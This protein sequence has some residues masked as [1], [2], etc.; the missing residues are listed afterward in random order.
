[1]TASMTG[2][3]TKEVGA[4]VVEE[5]DFLVAVAAEVVVE[6][7][8][9]T[10]FTTNAAVEEEDLEIPTVQTEIGICHQEM[11]EIF[12]LPGTTQGIPSSETF[13]PEKEKWRFVMLVQGLSRRTCHPAKERW[14]FVILVQ[15]LSRRTCHP[16]KERCWLQGTYHEIFH[17]EKGSC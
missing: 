13:H 17:P 6:V 4:A 7:V 1:M 16:G 12:L 15:G 3:P 11:A 10:T 9:L 2:R 5:E 14:H 8:D